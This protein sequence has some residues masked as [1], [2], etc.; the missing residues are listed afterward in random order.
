MAEHPDLPGWTVK[1]RQFDG[2][3]KWGVAIEQVRSDGVKV[4]HAVRVPNGTLPEDEAIATAI[5]TLKEWAHG[6]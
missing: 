2:G 4:R 3:T 6:R 1:A 5:P